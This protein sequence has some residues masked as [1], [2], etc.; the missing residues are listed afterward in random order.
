[1]AR[2]Y[3]RRRDSTFPLGRRFLPGRRRMLPLPAA[4]FDIA[5]AVVQPVPVRPRHSN[6]KGSSR[7]A[8]STDMV[9]ASNAIAKAL[10][11]VS[12]LD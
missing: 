8:N 1:M 4:L 7:C 6:R 5:P 2:T 9:V 12:S 10:S 11:M 3:L